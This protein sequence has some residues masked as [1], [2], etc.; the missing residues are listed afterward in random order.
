MFISNNLSKDL[1]TLTK[2]TPIFKRCWCHQILNIPSKYLISWS[3]L[4][5]KFEL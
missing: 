5:I 4:Q 1:T 3:E 2:K